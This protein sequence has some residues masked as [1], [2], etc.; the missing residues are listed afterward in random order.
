M[1]ESELIVKSLHEDTQNKVRVQYMCDNQGNNQEKKS[2][3]N[4]PTK[5]SQ[6]AFSGELGVATRSMAT[7]QINQPFFTHTQPRFLPIYGIIGLAH[8]FSCRLPTNS[9]QPTKKKNKPTNVFT[10][11]APQKPRQQM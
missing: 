2:N 6:V 11:T 7:R 8:F 5:Q 3:Y 10:W 4:Q 9:S 1:R